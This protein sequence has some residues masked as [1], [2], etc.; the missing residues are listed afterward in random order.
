MVC[1]YHVHGLGFSLLEVFLKVGSNINLRI[2]KYTVKFLVFLVTKSE[3]LV[4][5]VT[6][7]FGPPELSI[8]STLSSYV[9]LEL[10][11]I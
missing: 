4:T 7:C 3:C 2:H 9:S 5:V 11:G 10:K 8:F 1:F 6:F